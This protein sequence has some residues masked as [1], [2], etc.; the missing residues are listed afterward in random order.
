MPYSDLT[1]T[2]EEK[3]IADMARNFARE[4]LAPFSDQWDEEETFPADAIK[5]LGELGFMGMLVPEKFGGVGASYR[6]YSMAVEELAAG[7][8][9]VTTVIS[10][11]MLVN[12]ILMQVGSGEQ[13]EKYLKP[14]ARG[15]MLSAFCLSEPQAG[16]DASAL[17]TRAVRDGDNWII[18]GAKQFITNG[19]YADINL[20]FAVTDPQASPGRGISAFLVPSDAKGFIR[21]RKEKKMGQKASDATQLA[22]E[23]VA[24]SADMLVGKENHGYAYALAN[25]EAGR[26]GVASQSIGMARAAY[27]AALAYARQR[28]AFGKPIFSHQ[29]V[30]FRLADMATQLE[31][32]RQL[33]HHAANIRDSGQRCL[34]EACMAKMFATEAAERICHAAIQTLGGAGYTREFPVER[35]YR[36]VRVTEIYE[37]TNDIQ[38]ML[39]A[40]EIVR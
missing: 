26:I 27:E 38:R 4:R 37:G 12:A 25:L 29:A 10:V 9:P 22:F 36:D 21:V 5:E 6:G 35:L 7:N 33:T 16:S 13:K 17:M 1:A 31:A 8:G 28:Q 40:R 20:V 11:Q 19:S 30:A 39:I 14:L 3:M 23:D 18:N 34:K 15:S 2:D 32:A 24:V